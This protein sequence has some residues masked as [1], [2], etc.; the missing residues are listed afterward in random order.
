MNLRQSLPGEKFVWV[1]G[2][3]WVLKVTLVLRFGPNPGFRF[4][5]WTWTKLNN[6]VADRNPI[7]VLNDVLACRILGGFCS[8]NYSV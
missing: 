2:G 6:E 4:W 7:I 8:M 3:G 1:G 5:N